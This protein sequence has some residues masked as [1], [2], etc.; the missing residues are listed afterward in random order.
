M[1]C[2]ALRSRLRPWIWGLLE[3][4]RFDRTHGPWE[5]LSENLTT[6]THDL[7]ADAPLGTSVKYLSVLL[8]RWSGLTRVP[9]RFMT[10]SLL[11]FLNVP[12]FLK[13][14]AAL[15]NLHTLEIGSVDF[16]TWGP[17]KF[18]AALKGVKLPQIKTLVLC[19]DVHRFL[20]HCPNVEKVDWVARDT[21]IDLR[22]PLDSLA[23]IRDS[24]VKRLGIPLLAQGNPYRKRVLGSQGGAEQ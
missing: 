21:P 23:S 22:K 6:S 3:P 13:C 15:P 5:P 2:K 18:K 1:T 7:C 16:F 8:W 11:W 12:T 4:S 17:G 14:I 19:P 9:S 24:K 10:V 20:R